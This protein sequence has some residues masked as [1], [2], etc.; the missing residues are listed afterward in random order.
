[1]SASASLVTVWIAPSAARASSGLRSNTY[2][3][4]PAWTATTVML[5]ATTSCSSLAMRSRSEVTALSVACC[6]RRAA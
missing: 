6:R 3:P 4:N 5:C 1:M 2:S